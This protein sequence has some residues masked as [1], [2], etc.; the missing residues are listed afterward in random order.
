MEPESPTARRLLEVA[1]DESGYEGENLIGGTTD[2]FAHASVRLRTESAADCIREI[3][4]RIQ[5]PVQ[6]YKSTHLLR[7]KHRSVLEWF[8]GP[9][10]PLH[11]NAHVHLT[12]KTFFVVA[13]LIDLL[14][15]QA[16]DPVGIGPSQDRQAMAMA[17]ALYHQGPGA[18]GPAR[19]ERF[20]KAFTD[21]VRARNRRGP[22][23]SVDSF[24]GMV[25]VLRRASLPGQVGEIMGLLCHARPLADAL[26]AQLLDNPRAIPALDILFPAIVRAVAYWSA[27]GRPVAIT[28][29]EHSA[30]TTDRI[31]QLQSLQSGGRRLHSLRRVDSRS[32]ARVQVADFLAGVAR[33]IA[34]DERN[35]RGDATLTALLRRYV[36]ACSIWGDER[37]WSLLRPARDGR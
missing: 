8:L 36:D 3:H 19:W 5:S 25:D 35:G 30:L 37:S 9:S 23:T 17:A 32:D 28:H 29:D 2:V 22:E 6:E 34:S 26:R 4:R 11:G 15:R 12:D 20:L 1:C 31:A 13:K 14:V 16:A 21:L 24:F 10:G 27:G 18:F 7:E 33:R